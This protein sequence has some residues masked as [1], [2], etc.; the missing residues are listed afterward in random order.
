MDPDARAQARERFQNWQ[1]LPAE[2]R[3]LIRQRW[4]R[5]QQ[6]DPQ[7][8]AIVREN[9]NAYMH[10]PPGKRR[11][12]RERWLAATPEQRQRMIERMRE[13]KAHQH[14]PAQDGRAHEGGAPP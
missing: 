2:R 4:E 7:S 14:H 5:F 6:L 8:K 13:R 10:L 11:A 12:L 9:F 1:K 3:E